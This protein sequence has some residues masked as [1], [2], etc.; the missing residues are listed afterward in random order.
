MAKKNTDFSTASWDFL[1]KEMA[2]YLKEI[3]GDM[4]EAREKGLTEA[5][6]YLKK[7]L[8]LNTPTDTGKLRDSW[9][10]TTKY[11]GVRYINNTKTTLQH[12]QEV[13]A[14][15]IVEFSTKH[16]KPFV[17]KVFDSNEGKIKEIILNNINKEI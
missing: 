13:P 1:G 10:L 14:L 15:N 6:E 5:G 9:E 8:E 17:R 16:G 4:I 12:G 11:K 3:Q 2:D 7:E